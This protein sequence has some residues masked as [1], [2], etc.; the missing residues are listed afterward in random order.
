MT[1]DLKNQ[2]LLFTRTSACFDQ[3]L[4]QSFPTHSDC[5]F[6]NLV[7]ASDSTH[8]FDLLLFFLVQGGLDLPIFTLKRPYL[9]C[10]LARQ[11]NNRQYR[12]RPGKSKHHFRWWINQSERSNMRSYNI[13]RSAMASLAVYGK[14]RSFGYFRNSEN[15]S[16]ASPNFRRNIMG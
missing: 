14:T 16:R 2:L 6:A 12:K 13:F 1:W 3:L 15:V 10:K 7:M 11:F 8:D 4:E 9:T 5:F